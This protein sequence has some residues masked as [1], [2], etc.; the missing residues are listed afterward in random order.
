MAANQHL[1]DYFTAFMHS[2]SDRHLPAL[3]AVQGDCQWLLK[4][5]EIGIGHVSP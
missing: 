3:M 5:A 1:V 2:P 4:T